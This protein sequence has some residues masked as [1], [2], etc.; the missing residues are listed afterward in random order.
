GIQLRGVVGIPSP[1]TTQLLGNVVGGHLV[2]NVDVAD[3]NLRIARS[4][5]DANLREARS[6][7]RRLD[8]IQDL[9]PII[10]IRAGRCAVDQDVLDRNTVGLARKAGGDIAHVVSVELEQAYR[11]AAAG[12]SGPAVIGDA[13]IAAKVRAVG[14]GTNRI[15]PEVGRR[16]F[17]FR[18]GNGEIV[19]PG[20]MHHGH[21]QLKRRLAVGR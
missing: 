6:H 1:R 8:N 14:A 2:Q 15:T 5:V 21:T 20:D 16:S 17:V 4:D 9:F 12:E 18:P 11:L 7:R 10:T 13:H 3:T 19:H